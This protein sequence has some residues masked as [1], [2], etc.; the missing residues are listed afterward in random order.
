MNSWHKS[1]YSMREQSCVE[2]AEGAVTVMRD[3]QNREL[4]HLA[5]SASEWTS[6]VDTLKR[7]D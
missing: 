6:L 1:S 5:F 7:R 4:G 2:V 3:T